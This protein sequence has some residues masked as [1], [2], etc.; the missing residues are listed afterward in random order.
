MGWESN[1]VFQTII[2]T[3]AG[4]G[5]FVYDGSGNLRIAIVGQDTADPVQGITCHAGVSQFNAFGAYL[6]LISD[7]NN[8]IFQYFDNGSAVQGALVFSGASAIGTDPVTSTTYGAGQTNINA[9]FGDLLNVI[10]SALTFAT[11]LTTRSAGSRINVGGGSVRPSFQFDAPERATASHLQLWL[12]GASPDGTNPAQMLIGAVAGAATL[13]P[14]TKALTEAQG[15]LAL[16]NA[17]L[18]AFVSTAWQQAS[19]AGVLTGITGSGGLSGGVPLVQGDHTAFTVTAIT[20]T[21]LSN[22]WNIPAGDANADTTYRLTVWGNGTEGTTAQTL[23]WSIFLNGAATSQSATAAALTVSGAFR[24]HVEIILH[25]STT[26]AGGNG[27]VNLSGTWGTTASPTVEN[28]FVCGSASATGQ[29][30]DT[31]VTNTLALAVAWASAT[32]A[33]TISSIG[34]TFE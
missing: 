11:T 30:F 25:V 7:S 28:S 23:T 6:I 33:P 2:I 24:W 3:G 29:A 27:S 12:E 1:N 34:S 19:V 20:A 8:T 17:S 13:T 14:V 22:T 16:I 10:G 9:T 32:G 4:G 21:A 5:E 31:T 26:G 15:S 18:P